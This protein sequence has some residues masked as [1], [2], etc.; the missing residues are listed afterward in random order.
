MAAL[1]SL[2]AVYGAFDESV[3]DANDPQWTA[4][5]EQFLP[6]TTGEGQR[7]WYKEVQ[8]LVRR[9]A[10]DPSKAQFPDLNAALAELSN[11]ANDMTER[12]YG[13]APS[14]EIARDQTRMTEPPTGPDLSSNKTDSP[15]DQTD[16]PDV[17]QQSDQGQ[18]RNQA[19]T[20]PPLS[21]THICELI[22]IAAVIRKLAPDTPATRPKLS[23]FTPGLGVAELQGTFGVAG[24]PL[25]NIFR[26]AAAPSPQPEGTPGQF[27]AQM[28]AAPEIRI[29]DL[30]Q[31][32]HAQFTDYQSWPTVMTNALAAKLV[33][34]HVA[35]T[36]IPLVGV[37][38]AAV[39]ADRGSTASTA[40]AEIGDN[41]CAVLTTDSWRKTEGLTVDK[42]KNIVD[43]CNWDQLLTYFCEMDRLPPDSRYASQVLEHVSTDK[44][45]Y[46]LKTAL[47]YWKHNFEGGGILNYELADDRACLGDSGLVLVDNGYIH[48]SGN[49]AEG[50]VRIRTSKVVAIQGCSVTAIAMFA[51]KLGWAALS[52]SML[53][54]NALHP[55]RGAALREWSTNPEKPHGEPEKSSETPTPEEPA[56]PRLPPG[57]RGMLVKQAARAWA[58]CV[59]DVTTSTAVIVDKLY[60][61][62]LTA[63]DMVKYS[64]ELGGRLASEPWR[65]LDQLSKSVP[66]A[67]TD[68]T[69][70]KAAAA[71]PPK[72][73][74]PP[75]DKPRVEGGDDDTF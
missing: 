46:R 52:D 21:N 33:D 60:K 69:P 67:P 10:P 56:P 30:Q 31:L 26:L 28:A 17:P 61:G 29:A 48:I 20:A 53:F 14:P 4:K 59:E 73:T 72:G 42:V 40:V 19:G 45:I 35:T 66:T 68:T 22:Y 16:N 39:T 25:D 12:A 70:P 65:L 8:K 54:G 63:A 51:L 15:F 71:T 64:T 7:G 55:P 49:T 62:K 13:V 23:A 38:T 2:L 18:Q 5:V 37:T 58:T 3:E 74:T 41:Y 34:P 36:P 44:D 57:A 9:L 43:P 24:D 50:G 11:I 27:S 47:K 32:L 1:H 75:K 6:G